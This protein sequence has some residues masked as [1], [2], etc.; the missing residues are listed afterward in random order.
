MISLFNTL[1]NRKTIL[2][3][4]GPFG[5]FFYKLNTDDMLPNLDIIS[6]YI[7]C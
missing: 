6:L 3:K 2:Q 1:F 4:N 5:P 7:N